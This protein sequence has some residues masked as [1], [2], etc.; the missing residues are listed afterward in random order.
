MPS[1]EA[2]IAN[3]K[4]AIRARRINAAVKRGNELKDYIVDEEIGEM[5]KEA[6][7]DKGIVMEFTPSETRKCQDKKSKRNKEGE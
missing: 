2:S 7:K 5:V 1:K 6:L 4:L 3:I